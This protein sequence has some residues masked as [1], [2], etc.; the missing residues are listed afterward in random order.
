MNRQ[1]DLAT[2][3]VQSG[4]ILVSDIDGEVVML[5]VQQGT[6]SGL[7]A[8]ASEI[9]ELLATPRR[10]SEICVILGKRYNVEPKQCAED[11]LTYL[12]DLASDDTIKVVETAG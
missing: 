3:V 4:E 2:V 6:Y 11:V 12:N 7:D 5:N 9:W 10:V 1:I 8:V